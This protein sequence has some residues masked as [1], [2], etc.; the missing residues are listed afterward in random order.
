[1]HIQYDNQEGRVLSAIKNDCVSFLQD[2]RPVLNHAALFCHVV[3]RTRLYDVIFYS[4][5]QVCAKLDPFNK[6]EN[7]IILERFFSFFIRV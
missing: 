1:M 2:A 6:A 4:Y 5:D 3:G 7:C